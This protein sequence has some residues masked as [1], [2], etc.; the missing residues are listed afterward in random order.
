METV[1]MMTITMMMTVDKS[2]DDD[3]DKSEYLG[4]K[5]N[6]HEGG[7]KRFRECDRGGK[8]QPG[9]SSSGS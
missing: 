9:F 7:N 5:P 8:A 1:M 3:D 6:L 4:K 2:D